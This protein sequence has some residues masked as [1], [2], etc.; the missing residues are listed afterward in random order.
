MI[1][2]VKM[3]RVELT[4]TAY[5]S[6]NSYQ[7]IIFVKDYSLVEHL[8][9]AEVSDGKHSEVIGDV[10]VEPITAKDIEKMYSDYLYYFLTEEHD[11]DPS[12]FFT[13]EFGMVRE[14]IVCSK[15]QYELIQSM[16][17]GED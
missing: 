13:P 12:E 15:E 3:A 7:E 8:D 11:I 14:T 10:S 16:L 9:G 5:Y 2:E 6:G 1:K 17:N 4:A